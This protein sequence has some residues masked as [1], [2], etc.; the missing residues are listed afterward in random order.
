MNDGE[1]VKEGERVCVQSSLQSTLRT[2]HYQMSQGVWLPAESLLI[3]LNSNSLPLS[4][5]LLPSFLLFFLRSLS[6]SLLSLS[7]FLFFFLPSP[8]PAV[9]GAHSESGASSPPIVSVLRGAQRSDPSLLLSLS[10]SVS[11]PLSP[12]SLSSPCCDRA[13]LLDLGYTRSESNYPIGPRSHFTV[14]SPPLDW[15]FG[16]QAHLH[17]L[18][19]A[20]TENR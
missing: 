6:L 20:S 5:L 12:F 8:F 19:P 10:P 4:L 3:A 11:L 1:S 2:Y 16:S 17:S 14:S 18:C 13:H 15:I 7:L 9:F